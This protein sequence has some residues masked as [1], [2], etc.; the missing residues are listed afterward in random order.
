[1]SDGAE[2]AEPPSKAFK[3]GTVVSQEFCR[4]F[5][6]IR[7]CDHRDQYE[8]WTAVLAG[9]IGA[10]TSDLGPDIMTLLKPLTEEA[11][12]LSKVRDG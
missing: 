6:F 10:A 11:E 1:M 12:E 3:H 7:T 4:Q 5:A 2:P 9:L 8:W